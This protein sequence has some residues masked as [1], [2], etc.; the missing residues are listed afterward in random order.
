MD[1]LKILNKISEIY[2]ANGN[3]I[4]FL[5]N[6][7]NETSNN[8]ESILISYDFQS[9]S[10]IQIIES[11]KTY[12]NLYT[13]AIVKV[14]DGLGEFQTILEV[15]VGEATTFTHLIKKLNRKNLKSFGFDISFSRILYGNQYLKQYSVEGATL[16]TGDLFATPFRDNS[17]DV[18]Y[19]SHSLEPN[20]G[21]EKEALK[22]LYR[23]ARKYVVLLEPAYE[24]AHESARARMRK[25]GYVTKIRET[26][27]ELGYNVSEHRLFDVCSNPENPTGLTIISK[28][29]TEPQQEHVLVCPITNTK[30][31]DMEMFLFSREGML[32]YPKIMGIPC[33]LPQNAII[34]THLENFIPNKS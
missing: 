23:I 2:K 28:H 20:G 31:E 19:T 1:K 16:L 3:I 25:H 13:D 33:L 12:I 34:A 9:G 29:C 26:A 14:L 15:G 11:D 30:L 32:V 21:R 5:R 17:I 18:V 10:Y 24:L 6:E 27:L 22:E 7:Y 4:E 8:A